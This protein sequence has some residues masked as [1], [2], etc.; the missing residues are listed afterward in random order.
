[1]SSPKTNPDLDPRIVRGMNIQLAA[2]SRRLIAGE[3]SLG[4][5]AAFGTPPAMER[6]GTDAPLTGYLTDRSL[7]E[8][9]SS[10][11]LSGW[12]NP[13]LEPEIAVH[14]GTDLPPDGELGDAERAIGGI[15]PAFEL[16]DLD[17]P[18][19]DVEAILGGNI[20][21]RAVVVGERAP[22]ERLAEATATVA[23]TAGEHLEIEDPQEVTGPVIAVV[24]HIAN[25]VGFF[26]E[27]VRAGEIVICGSIVPPVSVALGDSY[28]YRLDPIGELAITFE[29]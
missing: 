16:A 1:M 29:A 11:S 15:G 4:W 18:P 2:R 25:R 21:Q 19:E 26:G 13:M 7:V 22:L 20:F 23:N 10:V 12:A 14:L 8:P 24:R 6:L 3:R 27:T 17:P 28:G 9:G 5:K